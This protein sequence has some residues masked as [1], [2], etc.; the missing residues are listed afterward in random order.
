MFINTLALS[1]IWFVGNVFP[2]NQITTKK[3]KKETSKYLWQSNHAEPVKREILNLPTYKGGLGI[4]DVQNQCLAL[5]IKHIFN[6]LENANPHHL[7]YVQKYI[8]AYSLTNFAKK[9]YPKWMFLTR[10]DSPKSLEPNPYYYKDIIDTLKKH[11]TIFNLTQKSSKHIYNHLTNGN[12]KTPIHRIERL[13]EEK[14]QRNLHWPQIWQRNFVSYAQGPSKNT[15]WRI[16]T[17]SLPTL[18]KLKKWRKNRGKGN[19]HCKTCHKQE[20]TLHPF[21]FCPVARNVWKNFKIMFEK[22]LIKKKFN[23]VDTL[24][25]I[26]TEEL[27]PKNNLAKILTTVTNIITTELWK[28]RNA[29]VMENKIITPGKIKEN[30]KKE[31]K[32]LWQTHYSK[33]KRENKVEMFHQL[34]SIN[35]AISLNNTPDLTF[36]I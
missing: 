12:A 1:K 6:I 18:E 4:L 20:T 17:D 8:L 36:T 14:L 10:N 16:Y 28:A 21:I 3:I 26:I 32:Y 25:Q 2:I 11:N 23:T 13:W 31:I 15:L 7:H 5:R 35:N 22:L 30:I 27:P 33:Y 9:S 29:R 19:D 34:F 24:F